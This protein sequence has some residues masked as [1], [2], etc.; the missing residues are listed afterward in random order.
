MARQPIK[1]GSLEFPT[2][3]AAKTYFKDMLGRYRNGQTVEETDASVLRN[4]IERHPEAVQKIGCGITR[5]FKDKTDKPTS[6]FWLERVDDMRTDFSYI[7]CVDAKGKSLYQEFAEACRMAVAEDLEKAKTQHFEIHRNA[8]GK[9]PCE[10]TGQDVAIYES[11]LDHMNP[12]TFQMIVET[13]VK[14][15]KIDIRPEMLTPPSD[16]Q[17]STTF[18]DEAIRDAFREYHHRVARLRIIAA[19]KNLSLGGSERLREPKN[20]VELV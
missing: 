7:S 12:M 8:D 10:V 5:F 15:T 19:K 4:L 18:V 3:K 17:F 13:F 16:C 2:K 1:I 9:V 20:P 14:A 11:H 6:C